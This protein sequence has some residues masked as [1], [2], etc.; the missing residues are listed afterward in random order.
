MAAFDAG[1]SV[2]W[3]LG[4]VRRDGRVLFCAAARELALRRPIASVV[5]PLSA[6]HYRVSDGDRAGADGQSLCLPPPEHLTGTLSPVQE[7]VVVGGVGGGTAPAVVH[8]LHP[9][10]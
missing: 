10:G 5:V 2:P 6:G 1:L 7:S 9:L 4:S 3:P 8:R